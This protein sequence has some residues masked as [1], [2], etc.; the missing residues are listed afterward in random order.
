MSINIANFSRLSELISLSFKRKPKIVLDPGSEYCIKSKSQNNLNANI[1]I[2][3]DKWEIPKNVRPLV[4]EISQDTKLNN[5]DKI[6]AIYKII[7]ENYT[8]DDN[9]LS[10]IRKIDDDKFALPDWYGRN[11]DSDWKMN[12]EKHDRRVCYEVSRILAK[13]LMETFKNNSDYNICI[14][15]DKDF[16]HYFVGL[17]CNEYSITLDVDDFNNIKDLTR[18]KV[19]LTAEGIVILDDNMNQFKNALDEFNKN[20]NKYAIKNIEKKIHN[21]DISEQNSTEEE[22]PDDI[23]FLRNAIDILKEK[24]IDSQGMF[25]Y[26]KEIV[27]INLGPEARKKI[28]KK[29]KGNSSQE[30]RYTRSLIFSLNNKKYI[31]DSQNK[32]LRLF[33][34]RE[35][36]QEDSEF[37][38]YN[39]LYRNWEKNYN[40][41]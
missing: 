10:Y 13:S 7:C 34:E 22:E 28:W 40:G 23:V 8:Y 6:L 3:I 4:D 32:E 36:T 2:D 19:G 41:R 30:E 33:D 16:T 9:I 14:L 29:V 27:D 39:N 38:P 21:T 31:I 37:V 20:R 11:I 24:D 26:M 5:E 15:W 35:L 17:T 1:T 18:L 12:R 25:E